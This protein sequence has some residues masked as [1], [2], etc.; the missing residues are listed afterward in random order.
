MKLNLEIRRP[1]EE[2]LV[3]SLPTE[4]RKT[5]AVVKDFGMLK[6]DVR[7]TPVAN[8][9]DIDV[10]VSVK[11][12]KNFCFLALCAE[13]HDVRLWNFYDAVEAPEVFRQ[14]PHDPDQHWINLAVQPV[15]LAGLE[16]DGHITWVVGDAAAH[17]ANFTTQEFDPT[18]GRVA[19]CSGDAGEQPGF[20]GLP[21]QS[22]YHEVTEAAPHRMQAVLLGTSAGA[23]AASR[24]H[25]Y[26][27]IAERWSSRPLTGLFDAMCFGSNYMHLRHN[28]TGYSDLWVVPGIE[29]CN[30]QYTRDA[31]WQ[32]MIFPLELDQQCY[33]AVYPVRYRYAENAALYLLWSMRIANAG[34]QV[35]E[36][37]AAD[38]LSWLE[39]HTRDGVFHPPSAKEGQMDFRSWYDLVSFED[40][41][42]I[43]YNQGLFAASL[44][45]ADVLGLS[46]STSVEDARAVYRGLYDEEKGFL[47]LSRRKELL[48]VDALAGDLLARLL[49][50]E[51]LLPAEHVHAHFARL[52]RHAWTDY[53]FKVTCLPDGRYAPAD[54][55]GAGGMLQSAFQDADNAGSYQWGGS[56]CL[57]DMLCIL[58]AVAQGVEGAVDVATERMR[59]EFRLGGAY[60]EHINT[61][62]GEPDK[63]GQGWN[64]C[65]P[66][67]WRRLMKA[68]LADD[69]LFRALDET[70]RGICRE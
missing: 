52:R 28:E 58:D 47:P 67:L 36:E 7:L 6:A 68:G 50:G 38:A 55:Y 31:F 23:I 21:M 59:I 64:A 60:H 14:S 57:Y 1:A 53:G 35:N 22:F 3:L 24:L 29:Y 34:G 48:C 8:R 42:C 15:P 39:T 61:R 17:A 2:P 25:L 70:L 49:F 30:K 19:V 12:G 45:A 11:D 13:A 10:E 18:R 33:D 40:D 66:A 65:V 5:E 26:E 62:T 32:S 37:R 43:A 20:Q 44:Q 69:R 4:V 46:A 9:I 63:P 51:S 54:A 56:W 27:A 16:E 41:D